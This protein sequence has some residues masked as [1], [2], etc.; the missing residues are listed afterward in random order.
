MTGVVSYQNNSTCLVHTKTAYVLCNLLYDSN[1]PGEVLAKLV[2]KEKRHEWFH[3][4]GTL[5]TMVT[6]VVVDSGLVVVTVVPVVLVVLSGEVVVTVVDV[7]GCGLVVV[8][9]VPVVV[10]VVSGVVVVTVVP[11]VVV[12]DSENSFIT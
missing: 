1:R 8:T 12:V 10:D 9:V 7:V 11:V 6:P 5:E 2:R 3:I 4:M